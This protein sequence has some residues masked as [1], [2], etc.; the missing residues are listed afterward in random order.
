LLDTFVTCEPGRYAK[1]NLFDTCAD[2]YSDKD[3]FLKQ[4]LDEEDRKY[5]IAMA[6]RSSTSLDYRN[7][8]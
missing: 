2:G 4:W 8:H 7:N 1:Y 3:F 6:V 5:E